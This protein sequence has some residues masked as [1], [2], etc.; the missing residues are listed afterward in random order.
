MPRGA[1]G[2]A[3]VTRERDGLQVLQFACLEDNY[4]FLLRCEA[5]GA[6]AVV[7]T[8]DAEEISARVE[9]AGGRL[10]LILNTHWHPDHTGGNESLAARYGAKVVGPEGEKARIPG[11]GR[12]VSDGDTVALG[13]RTLRV[14]GTPGHTAGHIAYHDEAAGMAFVCDTLFSLGCGRLFEGAPQQMWDS[15]SRLRALPPDTLIWCAH[16][17]TAANA[18]FARSVDPVNEA[19]AAREAEVMRLREAG[20]PSVPVRLGDELPVNPFLRADDPALAALVGFDASDP[21]GVFGEVR[22]RKDRF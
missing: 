17:Y 7:D 3:D 5:S 18:A 4:G 14:I 16:E 22:A 9:A 15:L 21:A 1:R 11:L 20:Q 6:V 10:D 12:A 8:P 13:E 19:L 2:R